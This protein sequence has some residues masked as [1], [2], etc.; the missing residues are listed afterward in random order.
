MYWRSRSPNPGVGDSR[1]AIF[2]TKSHL[3]QRQTL[4]SRAEKG[5]FGVLLVAFCFGTRFFL[6]QSEGSRLI[7]E[8]LGANTEQLGF[9]RG[10]EEGGP[11]HYS[12]EP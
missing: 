3:P 1:V 12:H 6:P 11:R 8:R 2:M 5:G 10:V 4:S 9:I 7:R